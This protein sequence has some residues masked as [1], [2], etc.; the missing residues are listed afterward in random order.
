MTLCFQNPFDTSTT[1]LLE[2]M[3]EA[4]KVAKS[5]VGIFSFASSP[6]LKMLVDDPTFKAFLKNAEF[7]LI[8][9][10]DAITNTKALK[11]L[12]RLRDE[13]P[14]FKPTAFLH[15]TKGAIFHLKVCWFKGSQSTTIIT[16]SG[17]M[18]AGG[19]RGN[20]EA[21]HISEVSGEKEKSFHQ[22]WNKWRGD[23]S[24][25]LKDIDNPE[26]IERAAKNDAVGVPVAGEPQPGSPAPTV[27]PSAS[28]VEETSELAEIEIAPDAA[29]LMAE[30]PRASDRWHQAN[31]N[32]ATVVDYFGVTPGTQQRVL[33]YPMN[34]QGHIGEPESRPVVAVPSKNY[35]FELGAAH[36]LEYPQKGRPIGVFIAIAARTFRYML[37]MPGDP[38]YEGVRAFL[39]SEYTGHPER[40]RRVIVTRAAAKAAYPALPLWQD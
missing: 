38:H 31:F 12:K 29:V 32:H 33:L 40:M 2:A 21:F 25:F 24:K 3:L 23:F 4:S 30:I 9:G 10:L 39:Y 5:G 27:V 18:T 36:G 37:L 26:V 14:N 11:E 7:E 15:T 6:G 1:F 35:R 8:V 16:G 13:N 20:W 17:N 34:Q 28:D 19:L 22:L